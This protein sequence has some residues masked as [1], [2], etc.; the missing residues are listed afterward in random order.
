MEFLA[1]SKHQM[2]KIAGEYGLTPAQA[3]VLMLTPSDNEHPRTMNYFCSL[4][5]CDASNITGIVDGLERKK[6]VKRAES[7][8]DRRVKVLIILPKGQEIKDA[9]LGQ[10][11]DHN[12]SYILSKLNDEEV[13]QFTHLIKKI[14]TGTPNMCRSSMQ[15][16]AANPTTDSDKKSSP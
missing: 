12:S 8:T 4:L 13:E 1:L 10:M 3:F 14:T 7:P 11:S 9:I 6:I 16:P 2:F 15:K 5:G